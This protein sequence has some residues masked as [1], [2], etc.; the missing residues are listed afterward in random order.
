MQTRM[1]NE[2]EE[3]VTSFR[4]HEGHIDPA[5]EVVCLQTPLLEARLLKDG[6]FP[7]LARL[8]RLQ[9]GSR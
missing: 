2:T 3:Q 7:E 1:G 4:P 6:L 8:H 9:N 5:F